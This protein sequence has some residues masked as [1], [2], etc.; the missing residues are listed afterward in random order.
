MIDFKI[1]APGKVILFGEHAVV[2]GKTAVATS[3]NLRTIATFSD[4][5]RKDRLRNSIKIEFPDIKLVFN[6]PFHVFQDYFFNDNFNYPLVKENDELHR[7]VSEFVDSIKDLDESNE[8]VTEEQKL[9]LRAFFFLFAY[10]LHE[11]RVNLQDTSFH[12]HLS[13]ELKVGAGLGSSASFAVCLSAGILRWSIL[14]KDEPHTKFNKRELDKISKYALNCEKIMHESPSGIDNSVCTYG[15][16]IKFQQ[17]KVVDVLPYMPKLKIVLVDSNVTRNTKD[18]IERAANLKNSY[19]DIIVPILDIISGLAENAWDTFTEMNDLADEATESVQ[20]R[21]FEKLSA[22]IHMNQ[23]LLFTLDV[24][25]LS[26]EMICGIA[27]E[28]SCEAKLTGAGGGGHAFILL[29]PDIE[30]ESI[31]LLLNQLKE[32]GFGATMTSLGGSGVEVENNSK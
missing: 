18:Q 3:V 32:K 16:V 17:G 5:Q 24:S 20:Y 8:I 23:G 1:S 14:Q 25:H 21:W 10:I 9:S 19:P 12:V 29:P 11:E 2:Y 28:H 4:R 6:I 26:L 30:S 31:N 13:T 15:S 27:S 22:I 7:R